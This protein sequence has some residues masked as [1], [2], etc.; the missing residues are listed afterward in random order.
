[1]VNAPVMRGLSEPAIWRR[2]IDHDVPDRNWFSTPNAVHTA[3]GKLSLLAS[4][5]RTSKFAFPQLFETAGTM[6]AAQFVRDL[7]AKP[8]QQAKRSKEEQHMEDQHITT[9][10]VGG[11]DT[12]KHL[13]VAAIVDGQDWHDRRKRRKSDDFDAEAA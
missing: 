9:L 8:P 5:D 4:I 11:A 3:E 13:H 6:A 10:A 1:M 12:H 7:A 2:S